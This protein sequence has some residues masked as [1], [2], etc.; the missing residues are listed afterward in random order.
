MSNGG[1]EREDR[2]ERLI[3]L[4]L[5]ELREGRSAS[6]DELAK[7]HPELSPE[8]GERLRLA[9]A[10]AGVFC[11]AKDAP[12]T[13]HDADAEKLRCPHCGN[14]V[15]L[16]PS[17]SDL[18]C[19]SCGSS[20]N[21]E[22]ATSSKA[23][24]DSLL[25][26][27]ALI[28]RIGHGAFGVVYR[29][30]D[31]ELDREVAVKVPRFGNFDSA[32]EATRFLKEARNAARLR[33]PR[34]VRVYDFG[35]ADLP[36]I[37][38]E[39]IEGNTLQE[40]VGANRLSFLEIANVLINVADALHYAHSQGIVHRDVKPS[41]ILM[42]TSRQPYV[43]DFGLAL[44]VDG[45][46]T[47][48][49]DGELIG[50]PV[51]MAPEQVNLEE[52]DARSDVYGLGAVMYRTLTD[53][54]PF[55][56]SQRMVLDQVLNEDPKP[57][58]R[59]NELI[60]ADL[61]TITLR[62]MAKE[63][64]HRFDSAK[65]FADEL[66]RWVND[67]TILSRP[68]TA[69]EKTL[70]WCRRHPRVA[71][72]I[73]L[74]AMLTLAVVAI[75][76]L[77]ALREA[78][79]AR[80]SLAARADALIQQG[81]V[82]N[83]SCVGAGLPH[84]AEAL[85]IQEAL[86]D[87]DAARANRMR[88]RHAM[89]AIPRLSTFTAFEHQID[90]LVFT[91]DNRLIVAS[92][93]E[94]RVIR[95]DD[96]SIESRLELRCRS[97]DVQVN[98]AGDRLV[99][100]PHA[101]GNTG[102]RDAAASE[103]E[104]AELW[105][106]TNGK[107]VSFLTHSEQ[108]TAVSFSPSQPSVVTT[109]LDGYARVW[110]SD[111]GV[112]EKTLP[113]PGRFVSNTW[114]YP[115]G[116][117]ALIQSVVPAS[118]MA[119]VQPTVLRL[120]RTDTWEVVEEWR[121]GGY[122]RDVLFSNGFF[123][124][125]ESGEIRQFKRGQKPKLLSSKAPNRVRVA[126]LASDETAVIK[127]VG[128]TTTWLLP[129]V[130]SRN[131]KETLDSLT[132]HA[133]DL[134]PDGTFYATVGTSGAIALRW[135]DNEQSIFLD[136]PQPRM[137]TVVRICPQ[138]RL[139]AIGGV[140][141]GVR[142][143]DLAKS[144]SLRKLLFSGDVASRPMFS[145]TGSSMAAQVD[146]RVHVWQLDNTNGGITLDWNAR[147]SRSVYS[148][149]GSSIATL[150]NDSRINIL[151][152]ES[153]QLT[154][155]QPYHNSV[156]CLGFATTNKTTLAVGL[157]TGELSL[158]DTASRTQ[159]IVDAHRQ[160][161]TAV[162]FHPH[163]PLIASASQDGSI[164]IVDQRGSVFSAEMRD[165]ASVQYLEFSVDGQKLISVSMPWV[166]VWN[167]QEGVMLYRHRKLIRNCNALL[168]S[169]DGIELIAPTRDDVIGSIRLDGTSDVKT[170]PARQPRWI[171]MQPGGDVLLVAGG[172]SP[173]VYLTFWNRREF[174]EAAPGYRFSAPID[175]AFSPDGS[176]ILVTCTNGD[177]ELLT[178]GTTDWNGDALAQFASLISQQ[179]YRRG[180][181][182]QGLSA[183]RTESLFNNWR[184]AFPT[185]FVSDQRQWDSRRERHRLAIATQD[186]L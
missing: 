103:S 85:K 52:A 16:V 116:E 72:T 50:T 6:A 2:I 123:A 8:L 168:A 114:F 130:A 140:D 68:A 95:I 137:A 110:R 160:P 173:A 86:G 13:L 25:E 122:I 42:D 4:F 96:W 14:R 139:V 44:D 118:T 12:T 157:S 84:L 24:T 112:L 149:D 62:A 22:T 131:R 146:G 40:Y 71:G 141:G 81:M 150:V 74:F 67:E 181:L 105:D 155:S 172:E 135:T 65:D 97:S 5:N 153:G 165:P 15:R 101:S 83:K 10:V 32:S 60:P 87:D 108:V 39:F 185:A 30:R 107:R 106:L 45:T 167:W 121:E 53:A 144:S 120:Y 47:V 186:D 64:E 164:R 162:E 166:T 147:S 177:V 176:R 82:A 174:I 9:D 17:G 20:F 70:K 171:R 49:R 134:S 38:S 100:R 128:R 129:S 73:G 93:L 18:F 46:V 152:A 158:L 80:S 142:V 51:Y 55:Q 183:E 26:R 138:N 35:N 113:Q 57:P 145:P 58:R 90:D 41:N 98:T 34:I 161:V 119:D 102:V 77:W 179:S 143:W 88:L 109:G 19:Q 36:F 33:H 91:S 31:K 66:R 163:Q 29:A 48:T 178:I 79:L 7:Q 115:S 159:V 99:A 27:F 28:D 54:L 78:T 169:R 61:E 104:L 69:F 151:D 11:I 76:S 132:D 56:G 124:V 182:I 1:A 3:D 43:A 125:T 75:L 21:F 89:D 111:S 156:T 175:M 127:S 136:L 170:I 180:K 154:Q 63:P 184:T 126:R 148:G 92:G 94:V 133:F 23:I 37:V 117:F 59:I